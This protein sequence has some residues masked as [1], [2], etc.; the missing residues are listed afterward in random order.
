MWRCARVRVRACVP[1]CVASR[2]VVV[3]CLDC[4]PRWFMPRRANPRYEITPVTPQAA[5]KKFEGVVAGAWKPFVSLSLRRFVRRAPYIPPTDRSRAGSSFSLSGGHQINHGL[6]SLAERFTYRGYIASPIPSS[7]AAHPNRRGSGGDNSKWS[8]ARIQNLWNALLWQEIRGG[9]EEK[10]RE[11]VR[12]GRA[13]EMGNRSGSGSGRRR[14]RKRESK[15]A[16]HG[17]S[18]SIA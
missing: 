16:S 4:A 11:R 18:W 15:Y 8:R 1:W 14:R 3:G 17:F 2:K 13:L 10:R 9:R 6:S 12:K 5:R 7:A